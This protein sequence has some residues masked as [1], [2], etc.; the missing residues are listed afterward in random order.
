MFGINKLKRE[1]SELTAKNSMLQNEILDYRTINQ[2]LVRE[3]EAYRRILAEKE[4]DIIDL[5]TRLGNLQKKL[6]SNTLVDTIYKDSEEVEL[7]GLDIVQEQ[8]V[9]LLKDNLLTSLK[10]NVIVTTEVLTD[11]DDKEYLLL[12]ASINTVVNE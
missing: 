10:P 7:L 11:E 6:F 3:D 9:D 1:I 8:K 2:K 4:V 5:Q 12:K